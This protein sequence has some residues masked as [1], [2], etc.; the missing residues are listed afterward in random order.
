VRRPNV[1]LRF[2]DAGMVC[3]SPG[4]TLHLWHKSPLRLLTERPGGNEAGADPWTAA[5]QVPTRPAFWCL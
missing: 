1:P 2:L 4:R 3:A 5:K